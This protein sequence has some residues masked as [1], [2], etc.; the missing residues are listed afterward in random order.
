[1]S[2]SRVEAWATLAFLT[3]LLLPAAGARAEGETGAP[4]PS[5]GGT[6]ATQAQDEPAS[7]A[8]DA[9]KD[10]KASLAEI[11]KE[12]TD[13]VSDTWSVTLAQSFFRI[14]PG[15]GATDRWNPRLQLQGAFPIGITS[16]LDLITRPSIGLMNSQPHPVFGMPGEIDRTTAFG[17]IV[18]QQL[19][20]PRRAWIGNWIFGVGPTWIFPSGTSKWTSARKWQVGPAAVLG[21]LSENWIVAGLVQDWRSFA[22]SGPVSLHETSIQPI[23]AYFFS[24]GW[25]IGY[26][27][28]ILAV[29]TS[30]T[31]ERYTIPL[32]LQVGKVVR[33]GSTHV[34][35]SLGGQWMPVH[36]DHFGQ[37]WNAQLVIQVK[38]PKLVRG[39]LSDPANLRF[40]WEE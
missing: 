21:Y 29:W 10:A 1:M 7:A 40:R 38:R 32:G 9:G 3:F 26:S 15:N 12:L 17:D 28:D 2:T 39:T 31:K 13:P 14:T 22:G 33:L 25:S 18:L 23:A 6:T 36:P 20:V 11:N 8:P 35:V 24:S 30:V 27:G 34:K 37:V 5:G 16:G 4:E 19:L